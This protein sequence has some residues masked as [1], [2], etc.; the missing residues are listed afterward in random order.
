MRHGIR[1]SLPERH[2]SHR[3]PCRV[4]RGR[5]SGVREL[6][7][8]HQRDDITPSA[9]VPVICSPE[10][11]YHWPSMFAFSEGT[12]RGGSGT[13]VVKE[14][15]RE[16]GWTRAWAQRRIRVY[17]GD[18]SRE[19]C[20]PTAAHGGEGVLVNCGQPGT[21]RPWVGRTQWAQ[22]RCAGS[23]LTCLSCSRSLKPKPS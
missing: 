22:G 14:S 9:T 19:P 7:Q 16:S 2:G 23:L 10:M 11:I 15:R 13:P 4:R 3:V 21:G 6:V 1:H 17:S 12:A 5:D 8:T 18:R 20:K